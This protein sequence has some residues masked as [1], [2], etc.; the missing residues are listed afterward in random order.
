MGWMPPFGMDAASAGLQQWMLHLQV[1]NNGCSICRFATLDVP[2]AGLQQWMLHLQVCNNGCTICRFASMDVL[3]A[4]L[5]QWMFYLQVCNN[6]C[7]TCRFAT[8]EGIV[9]LV[10]LFQQFTF[11]LNEAKHGNKPLEQQSLIT[12]MPKVICS[13]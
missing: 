10:R 4:G 5:Q 9:G 1:C 7:C 8:M 2:S 13:L 11:S 3:S 12:L 6:G